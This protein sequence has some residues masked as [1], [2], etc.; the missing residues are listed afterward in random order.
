VPARILAHLA[1][2]AQDEGALPVPLAGV[3]DRDALA[4]L[5]VAAVGEQL[6]DPA[7]AAEQL[8]WLRLGGHRLRA[9]DGIPLPNLAGA[10]YPVPGLPTPDPLAGPDDW[11]PA[12]R[13]LAYRDALLLLATGTDSAR[14][15]VLTGCALQRVLLTATRYGLATGFLNQPIESEAVRW[16]LAELLT[17]AAAPQLLL[18]IGYPDA[19]RP[20]ATPRRQVGRPR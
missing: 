5:L 14:E 4:G 1:T 6:A 20:P 18:R 15:W 9:E 17:P 3:R 12:V 11:R 16:R 7:R 19:P 8:D 2:E 13:G 10:R